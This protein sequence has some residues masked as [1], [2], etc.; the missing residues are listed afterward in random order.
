MRTMDDRALLQ[1]YT[2]DHSE[3]AFAELVRRHVNWVYS[4]AR[5]QVND[6][7]LAEDITQ[8]V[9]VL[10]AR[11]A[12]SLSS[13]VMLG[14]WLFRT[15]WFVA[16]R[17]L[18]TEMRRK[19]REQ[20][21][22]AMNLS[23][24]VPE[25]NEAR[26]NQL[27]PHLDQAVAALSDADRSAVLLRFYEKKPL[28]DVGLHLGM[29]E[30]AA[31]KRI[32]RALEK[33]R[34][35]LARRG[36]TLG[37]AT[38]ASVLAARTVEAAP[39]TL[40][41]SVLKVSAAG[42]SALL[43]E[44]ARQTL[45]AW[46]LTKLKLAAG[47][48][49]FTAAFLFLAVEVRHSQSNS[50]I[51]RPIDV[52]ANASARVNP[53]NPASIH[54]SQTARD[55]TS[56]TAPV[57]LWT[58]TVLDDQ[59]VPVPGAR[60]WAGW[61]FG[62]DAEGTTDSTGHFN[63]S[64]I[65][66][67]NYV[68]I[69]ADGYAV[70]QQ[71]VDT[72]KPSAPIV[73][74]LTAIRPLRFRVTNEAGD[75]IAGAEVV[76][77]DWWGKNSSLRFRNPTDDNGRLEWGSAPKGELEFCVLKSGYRASRQNKL[78]ANDDEHT[79]VLLPQ[80]VATGTV[81][82]AESG[83]A[84]PSFKLTRGYSQ[85]FSGWND[86]TS[87]IWDPDQRWPGTNGYYRIVFDEQNLPR[88]RVEADGYAITEAKV[89]FTNGLSAV[90]NFQLQSLDT[91]HSIR[92]TVVLPDGSPA[93]GVDVALC[94][95]QVGVDV[96]GVSF[97]KHIYANERI[98][99]ADY[100][101]KTGAQGAFSFNPRPGAHTVVA[102]SPA[103]IGK[104]HCFD[105]S[106][107]LQIH[108]EP[109]GRIEGVVRARDGHWSNRRISWNA[110]GQLHSGMDISFDGEAISTVSGPDGDFVLEHV[111][112]GDGKV[113]ADFEGKSSLCITPVQVAPGE[114]LRVQLGGSGVQ[115]SGKLIVPPGIELRSWSN[116]LQIAEI[117][118]QW[119]AYPKPE[120]LA[121]EA[122]WRWQLEYAESDAGRAR[123]RGQLRCGLNIQPDGS[124]AVSEVPPGDYNLVICLNEG[125]LGSGPSS[126]NP[127]YLR[128][129]A[130]LWH[131]FKVPEPSG[132]AAAPIN[133][134]ELVLDASQ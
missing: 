100:R 21:A 2:K 122:M 101:Q 30:D 82:D 92:G 8:S 49:G 25:E 89:Q 53:S 38:L 123:L 104:V 61:E 15:T 106:Q 24:D 126:S 127:L 80:R 102:I 64:K 13:S 79:F 48:V 43:P 116:Q 83:N 94:T 44:L 76:L 28:A 71:D 98:D 113:R 68:T 27:A 112:P 77:E 81:T 12:G 32:S 56:A 86:E 107:P 7:Q 3:S 63:L 41:A 34:E 65:G 84:I 20:T 58:G 73:F 1:A 111:P 67:R 16:S 33:M 121:G 132:D 90:C 78:V 55:T 88:L 52:A 45:N 39:A 74:H 103:G 70:D 128:Q 26:W 95:F 17:A 87:P 115:V 50:T 10:L 91:N 36:A 54:A 96:E 5:R 110:L 59:N 46:R 11:K 23:T 9:F 72:N 131:K 4:A 51:P 133:L 47:V 85:T 114:T 6:A 66:F 120:G 130:S 29:S 109:W 60:V 105:S 42:A 62:P 129:I 69:L 18:R 118:S 19:R 119:D 22:V 57:G 35:F 108:L 97:K 124:F 99:P 14:G 134:G 75:P 31:K 125:P 117:E 40:T 37:V 93:N